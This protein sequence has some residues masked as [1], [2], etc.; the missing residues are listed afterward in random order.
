MTAHEEWTVHYVYKHAKG[1]ANCESLEA[2]IYFAD[3]ADLAATQIV[4]PDGTTLVPTRGRWV[5]L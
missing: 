5:V 3:N 4:S 1:Q 2:A